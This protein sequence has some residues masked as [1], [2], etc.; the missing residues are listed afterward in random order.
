[1]T[2]KKGNELYENGSLKTKRRS[3]YLKWNRLNKDNP[4][5]HDHALINK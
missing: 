5:F 1:M 4:R 2:P 3:F